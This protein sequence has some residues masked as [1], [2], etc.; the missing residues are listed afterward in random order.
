MSVKVTVVTQGI[1]TFAAVFLATFYVCK[2]CPL[3]G[4][5]KHRKVSHF[6]VQKQSCCAFRSNKRDDVHDSAFGEHGY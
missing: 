1:Q 6:Q 4:G 2:M 5:V 3:A